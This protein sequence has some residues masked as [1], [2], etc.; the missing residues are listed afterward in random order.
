MDSLI[1]FL[2][3]QVFDLVFKNLIVVTFLLIALIAFLIELHLEGLHTCLVVCLVLVHLL[4]QAIIFILNFFEGSD[5]VFKLF[6]YLI[7]HSLV[8]VKIIEASRVRR[9]VYKVLDL[10]LVK[11]SVFQ[12]TLKVDI[13]PAVFGQKETLLMLFFALAEITSLLFEFQYLFFQYFFV[14]LH[15]LQ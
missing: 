13:I 3:L 11:N 6:L 10:C 7:L 4:L 12:L 9:L 15:L 14:L 5:H 1:F 2:F 8:N